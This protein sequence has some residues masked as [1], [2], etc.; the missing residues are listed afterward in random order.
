MILCNI[1]RNSWIWI[2]LLLIVAFLTGIYIAGGGFSF[3][4]FGPRGTGQASLPA[5]ALLE[6][7]SQ[8][9]FNYLSKQRSN[10]CGLQA[11]SI[12]SYSDNQNLQGSCCNPMDLHKYQEQVKGIAKYESLRIVPQDPYDVSVSLAK[13]LLGYKDSI[14]LTSEQQKVYDQAMKLS[15]E[16]GPCCCKCWRWDAFEGQAKYFITKYNWTSQQIADV[17]DIED[18]C[19][20]THEHG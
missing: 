9:K 11:N 16:G 20:G 17:W 1:M 7:G 4:K 14:K 13:E 10:S 19:G 3:F 15:D 2:T 18:G 8:E 5:V 12:L 6:T